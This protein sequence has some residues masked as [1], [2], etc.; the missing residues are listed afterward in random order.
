MAGSNRSTGPRAWFHEMSDAARRALGIRR[1][2]TGG[3][4]DRRAAPTRRSRIDLH[5]RAAVTRK[6]ADQ[7]FDRVEI[8]RK[9]RLSQDTVAMLLNLTPAE[10]VETSGSG[11]FF[12]IL[13]TRMTG[14]AA[15]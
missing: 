4:R 11:T 14:Q 10:P 8:A 9:T 1:T 7:G 12:R 2:S 15:A 6:L 3:K 13:Q 5:A